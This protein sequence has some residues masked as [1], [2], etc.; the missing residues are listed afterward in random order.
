MVGLILKIDT[1]KEE[2]L[3]VNVFIKLTKDLVS[4][5]RIRVDNDLLL[6]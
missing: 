5:L 1:S 6:K 4:Q 2:T 3:Q